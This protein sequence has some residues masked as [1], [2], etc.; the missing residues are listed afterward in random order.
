[1]RVEETFSSNG[2]GRVAKPRLSR[3]VRSPCRAR[4]KRKSLP[5]TTVSAPIG[6]RNSSAKACGSSRG[7]VERE[8]DDERRL[9]SEPGEQLQ[10]TLERHQQV[11]PVAECGARVR[12]ERDDRRLRPCVEQR[13]DHAAVPEMNPVEGS[14]R[15]CA[16]TMAQL[17][18]FATNPHPQVPDTVTVTVTVPGTGLRR[19]PPAG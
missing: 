3:S 18:R 5:A 17:A 16:R 8:L 11:D 2:T 13:L 10:P 4:P 6:R 19:P 15:H 12:I 7:D 9:D 1:M 14:E